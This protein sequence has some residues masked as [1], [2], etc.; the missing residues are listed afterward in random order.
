MRLSGVYDGVAQSPADLK[1]GLLLLRF[2]VGTL[3]GHTGIE[4][5]QL[6]GARETG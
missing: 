1:C 5:G 2:M 4:L 3:S 6:E